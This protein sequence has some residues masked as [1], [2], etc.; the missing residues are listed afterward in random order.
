MACV[1]NKI[2]SIHL[3]IYWCELYQPFFE[4]N[5]F[6]KSSSGNMLAV[7]TNTVKLD[8]LVMLKILFSP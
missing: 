2:M 3:V 4:Q 1:I 7:T 5:K 8:V 6:K